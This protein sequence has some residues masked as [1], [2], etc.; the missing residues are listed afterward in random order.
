[1]AG[2]Y[3]SLH[4]VL[5]E[6]AGNIGRKVSK[7]SHARRVAT[8]SASAFLDTRPHVSKPGDIRHFRLDAQFGQ[9]GIVVHIVRHTRRGFGPVGQE[10]LTIQRGQ[11]RAALF[12]FT[13]PVQPHGEEPLEN[14]ASLAMA[15]RAAM[16]FHKPLD[17]LKSRYDPFFSRRAAGQLLRLN[18]YPQFGEQCI[19]FQR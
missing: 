14:V 12:L 2:S 3:R 9:Q 13:Y 15:R 18:L 17:F 4:R 1:M 19:V 8:S 5:A 6:P 7:S 11:E 10:P 16:R